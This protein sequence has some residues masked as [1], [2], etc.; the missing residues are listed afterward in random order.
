MLFYIYVSIGSDMCRDGTNNKSTLTAIA[1]PVDSVPSAFDTPI[2]FVTKRNVH[3]AVLKPLIMIKIRGLR[4]WR[5]RR[6]IS[7]IVSRMQTPDIAIQTGTML[8]RL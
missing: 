8:R 5:T 6:M 1:T 3:A 2:I 4:L 7:T